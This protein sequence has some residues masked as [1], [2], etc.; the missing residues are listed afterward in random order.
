VPGAIIAAVSIL[1]IMIYLYL[2]WWRPRQLRWGATNEEIRCIM[3]GDE[4]VGLPSFNATRAV[5]IQASPSEIYPWI[6]QM[7]LNRAGWYSYDLL[8]NLGRKSEEEVLPIFQ[9]V[10]VGTLI[11]MSP[12]NNLGLWVKG[13]KTDG[14]MLWWDKKGNATWVWGIYPKGRCDC[15]L[16]SR[17]RIKY[18]WVGRGIFFNILIEFFDI[19]MM[20]KCMLGIKRRAELIAVK[21]PV[22]PHRASS[23][24]KPL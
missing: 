5:T 17:K 24:K 13:F 20:R 4:I 10:Q 15:R 16:V 2:T 23:K 9:N 3:P 21:N 12:N 8:D 7:G 1:I 6:V 14:W 22:L 11:P 19:L 18:Q